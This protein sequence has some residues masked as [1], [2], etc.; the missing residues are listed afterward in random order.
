MFVY[1]RPLSN[2]QTMSPTNKSYLPKDFIETK[3]GLCFAV[4]Q[5]S[6]EEHNGLEKVLCFLRYINLDPDN[7]QWQKVSTRQANEFLQTYYPDYLFHSSKLDADLHAVAIE[8]IMRHYE[9]RLRLQHILA[10]PE[11]DQVEDD[12]TSL[13]KLFAQHNVD[14]TFCGVTG[15]LL[16]GTQN[17]NSDI[18][19][20]FYDREVFHTAR[21]VTA[22]LI[23][24]QLLT[25]LKNKDWQR[26]Y[27]RR[28]CSLS[29]GEYMWHEHRK[30][31]KALIN[32]RKFDLS[33]V[34]EESS[35]IET[36]YRKLGN[37]TIQCKITEDKYN[38]D[39]PALYVIDHKEI[40]EVVC[41]TATYNGQAKIGETV[42]VSGLLEQAGNGGKR[43]IVGSSR[44][45]PGE[46]IKVIQC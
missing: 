35:E 3:E 39:Y 25:T 22:T 26:A 21:S 43:V 24:Q 14:M 15:S 32:N 37:I 8:R 41:F 12:L 42:E 46:Y 40:T 2:V 28:S 29:F 1:I 7:S 45:A 44:E 38:F 36:D 9:P 30:F 27:D 31:N 5:Q 10:K 4:V 34:T 33:F 17:Y 6:L 20:V 13:V 18:D 23:Q 11:R 19:L 16:L